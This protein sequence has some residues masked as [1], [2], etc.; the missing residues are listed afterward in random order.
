MPLENIFG[1]LYV[2]WNAERK[3]QKVMLHCVA[4]RN[5][6]KMVLDCFRYMKN[7]K[8]EEDS[9]LMEN[10]KDNQLPGIY[11]T[12]VFLKKCLEIFENPQLAEGALIDWIKTETFCS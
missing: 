11:R 3:Q 1:S 8:Y 2:L 7:G 10:V 5:R 6:S 12:E 9:S 4:G